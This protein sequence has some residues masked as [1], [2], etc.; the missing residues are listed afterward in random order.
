[1]KE[2]FDNVITIVVSIIDFFLF[3]MILIFSLFIIAN[4]IHYMYND[5]KDETRKSN[6]VKYACAT[7]ALIIATVMIN[8]LLP[9]VFVNVILPY[10]SNIS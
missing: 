1:M 5:F 6:A 3:N 4:L 8:L 10:Y 2:S 7:L 9:Q